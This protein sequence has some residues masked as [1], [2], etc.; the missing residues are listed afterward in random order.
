VSSAATTAPHHPVAE[1]AAGTAALAHSLRHVILAMLAAE[2]EHGKLQQQLAACR[3]H[4]LP[5]LQPADF[6]DMYA[7]TLA[8]LL[9]AARHD[10]QDEQTNTPPL[11]QRLTHLYE[12]FLAAY[13]PALRQMRGVYHTPP[14]LVA[15]IVAAVDHLLRT[16]FDMP[17]GLADER[18]A[19]LDPATG[20]GTFLQ[21]IIEHIAATSDHA[22]PSLP[23]LFGFEVL[24]PPCAIAHLTLRL[25]LAQRGFCRSGDRDGLER[26][27]LALANALNLQPLPMP[28]GS[29]VLVVIGNPPYAGHSANRGTPIDALMH[30]SAPDGSA[31]ASYYHVDGQPLGER[32]PKW[33]QDDYAR[34][35]RL[36][37]WHIASA[38][39]GILAFVSNNGYLDNPTFRG[40][41][42]SLLH[43]F[44]TIYIINLHG[45]AMQKE[46][47]P[48]HTY[49]KNVFSIQ[50]GVAIGLF[51]RRRPPASE[52]DTT[53]SPAT[54]Y[55]TDLW[56]TREQKLAT[57][58]DLHIGTLPWQRLL[59][60]A[61]WYRFVPHDSALQAE[62]EQGWKVTDIFPLHGVGITTARD[63]VVIHWREEPLLER[64][65]HFRDSPLPDEAL[66]HA[67][68][69]PLKKGWDIARA[70]WLLQQE[71]HL[72][73]AIQP[74]LYRPFDMRRIFYHDAL[75][76]RTVRQ[77][78]RHM[79][80]GPNVGLM[81]MRQVALQGDYTHV[82]VSQILVDNRTFYSNRGVMSYAPLYRYPPGEDSG[83]TP[84]Q[85]T[86]NLN[87]AFVDALVQTLG[88]AYL[89]DGSGDLQHT[90]GPEDVLHYSY[91]VLHS[92]AYRQRYAALLKIDF[93][94]VPLTQS[95]ALFA[96]L[97][98]CGAR[99]VDLHLLRAPGSG[100]VGGAGGVAAFA[101]PQ[102]HGVA[103]VGRGDGQALAKVDRVRYHAPEGQQPGSVAINRRER[104]TGIAPEVWAMQV[105]GYRPLAKWL[106]ER[107]GTTLQPEDRHHY[108]CM[109][110]ALRETRHIMHEIERLLPVLPL[111]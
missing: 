2:G 15:S 55:Y 104:F 75:V 69:I 54:L 51:V 9:A 78:M 99:L 95:R 89:P 28:A 12:R 81:F 52:H 97:A 19:V 49:D 58:H 34:F 79:L 63:R 74:L 36:G 31:T 90:I 24:L 37:Q 21:A 8:C 82:G 85:R 46:K 11:P 88:L 68:G 73:R 83:S 64:A 27:H 1:S 40:M 67:L 26:L 61:P 102:M 45:S 10:E 101:A 57:L 108:L 60:T 4:A 106:R 23:H 59:P 42:Q 6:A 65:R 33:L 66:C 17:A 84:G 105:G 94:R 86:A 39:R 93:P 96:A 32:N 98:G 62:Y 16:C 29:S 35:F 109:V 92:T 20:T 71:Q 25:L 70:R 22:A 56:G 80:A 7:Q 48:H 13:S 87:P 111:T 103:F 50:Q 41:R 91:A 76:W 14:P 18:V 47:T 53:P 3:S 5:T 43:D 107:K 38:G 110:I 100:G 44:D 30:G 72:S 77:I